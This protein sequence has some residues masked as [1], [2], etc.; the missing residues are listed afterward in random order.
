MSDPVAKPSLAVQALEMA[1]KMEPAPPPKRTK[2]SKWALAAMIGGD[3]ADIGST[4]YALHNGAR[5]A[6]HKIMG[7]TLPRIAA[8]KAA[9]TALKALAMFLMAKEHPRLADA[10]GYGSAAFNGA[11]A[12]HNMKL[13]RRLGQDK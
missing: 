5:E 7:S 8:T 13:G 9:A 2:P 1:S 4:A 10:V 11:V 6:N 3:V 12:Y